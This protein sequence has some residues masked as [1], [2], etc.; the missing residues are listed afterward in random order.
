VSTGGAATTR[1][2]ALVAVCPDASSTCTVK[3]YEPAV[4]GVPLSRPLDVVSVI[5]AG[6]EPEVTD[7]TKG[8][9]PPVTTTGLL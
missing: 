3:A 2:I 7:H 9:V 4:V 8:D 1:V 6:S 5:P